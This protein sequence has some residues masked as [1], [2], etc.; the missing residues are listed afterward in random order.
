M[1]KIICI[2]LTFIFVI[3]LAACGTTEQETDSAPV[4]SNTETESEP[5]FDTVDTEDNSN[6]LSATADGLK[7]SLPEKLD[8]SD[9]DVMTNGDD[10][11]GILAFIYGVDEAAFEDIDSYFVTNS[12]RSTDA[13]ALAVIFFK[14]GTSADKIESVKNSIETIFVKNLV[15]TTATYDPEQAKIASAASFKVYDNALAFASYDTDG[16]AQ[17]FEAIEG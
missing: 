6:V 11:L 8:L 5:T 3:S 7:A 16:N 2:L 14:E 9:L 10:K 1:K 15:N 17:V 13:R 12:H 4:D